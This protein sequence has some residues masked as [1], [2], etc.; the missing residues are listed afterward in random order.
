MRSEM[1]IEPTATAL[2]LNRKNRV[3]LIRR[4]K[5]PWAGLWGFPGGHV[6]RDESPRRAVLR[7]VLEETGL[8]VTASRNPIEVF[9]Y[10]VLDH[11]HLSHLFRCR[12]V[13]SE[14]IRRPKEWR[15]EGEL[16]W[17]SVKKKDV[18]PVVGFVLKRYF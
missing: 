15:H 3:L 16:K 5:A 7:E 10:P 9:F 8:K 4:T 18:N 1:L 2:V 17:C 13:G 6:D 12:I 14:K 11:H